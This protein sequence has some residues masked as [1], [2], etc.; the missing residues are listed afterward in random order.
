[1][2]AASVLGDAVD[3]ALLAHLV[4]EHAD[5]LPGGLDELCTAGFLMADQHPG[6]YRFRHALTRD[7]AYGGLLKRQRSELHRRL[8]DTM[9]VDGVVIDDDADAAHDD[10]GHGTHCAGIIAACPLVEVGSDNAAPRWAP[11]LPDVGERRDEALDSAVPTVWR[12][13][14]DGSRSGQAYV[15]DRQSLSKG[16]RPVVVRDGSDV[17]HDITA[18]LPAGLGDVTVP[19]A[20]LAPRVELLIYKIADADGQAKLG[21]MARALHDAVDEGADIISLSI[22]CER[23]ADL[24]Y[25]AVH[26]VLASRS[27]LICSAGNRGRL[28]EINIGYPARNGGVITVAAHNRF[29]Q[30][31]AFSS[32]GGEIDMAAP[33]EDI[34]STWPDGYA[35]RSGTSM[36]APFVAGLSALVLSKHRRFA[37][38]TRILRDGTEVPGQP[39]VTAIRNCEEMREH[40]L[41]M[42][43]HR[44]Y[45]DPL[46]G[47]GPLSPTSCFSRQS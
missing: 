45:Y 7:A 37:T 22:Q 17:G 5:T 9:A 2:R 30:P 28:D 40:L 46:S 26:R 27:I 47:Y 6:H 1:L 3:P 11:L 18:L 29:G 23:S 19:F 25:G 36:A 15:L 31:S 44:G 32:V 43:A 10:N 21:D 8:V 35:K 41:L 14:D 42:A 33:G 12:F 39:N 16:G 34:W 20:G 24:L 13:A 4:E 38:G